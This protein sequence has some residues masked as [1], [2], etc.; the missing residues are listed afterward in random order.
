MGVVNVTPDSFSDGG[1]FLDPERATEH[2]LSLIKQGADVLD[3]G[4][5]STRP[6]AAPVAAEEELRRILP[7][8]E[9][10]SARGGAP[11]SVDTTKAEVAR[12]A[13][14]AGARIVNDISGGL[15]DPRMIPTV[16]RL[17]ED[18]DVFLVLMHRQG[19][20]ESMQSAPRYA[21]ALAEVGGCLRERME[22]AL[23]AGIPPNRLALD[24]GIGFGKSLEHNLQLLR[25]LSELRALGPPCSSA[26]PGSP[27]SGTS[28]ARSAPPTG[29]RPPNDGRPPSGNG[30][31]GPP[32]RSPSR[33]PPAAQTSCGCMTWRSCEKR[34][35][36]PLRSAPASAW[37]RGAS[38]GTPAP[39][40]QIEGD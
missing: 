6:G 12:R 28:R 19:A 16:A 14:E 23:A 26:C 5:E 34:P 35:S 24:P 39:E 29:R 4:G 17:R 7:V 10:L 15:A 18:H 32:P 37:P 36:W 27:S 1:Q 2:G 20:P 30:S 33:S 11:I 31:A 40:L 3:V 8:I 38:P 21:D 25:G 22:A 9:A 13:V